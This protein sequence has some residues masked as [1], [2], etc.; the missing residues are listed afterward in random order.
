MFRVVPKV[1]DVDLNNDF[2]MWWDR[3]CWLDAF[4]EIPSTFDLLMVEVDCL[5]QWMDLAMGPQA[6][7][8]IGLRG[9]KM[10]N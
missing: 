5:L 1:G 4:W 2:Y 10:E 6:H 9:T 7:G 3:G 8:L